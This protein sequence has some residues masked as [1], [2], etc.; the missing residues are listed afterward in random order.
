MADSEKNKDQAVR[1]LLVEDDPGLQR[2]MKWALAPHEVVGVPS[3]SEALEQFNALGPFPIVILDLG[4]PP[5]EN[6]ATE[7]LKLLQ[8]ILTSTPRTKVIVASGHSDRNSA[9][10]DVARGAFD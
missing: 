3:R 8:D 5:D 9:I 10:Q 2:Q 1:V 7:G 6:G 4:L